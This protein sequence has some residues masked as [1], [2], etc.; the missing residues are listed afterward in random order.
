MRRANQYLVEYSFI[1][2]IV[3]FLVLFIAYPVFLNFRISF[4]DLRAANLLRGDAAWVGFANYQK[5][6]NDPLVRKAAEHLIMFTAGSLTFQ[7]PIGLGLALFFRQNFL[8]SKWMRGMFLLAWTMPII[9]VGAIFRWLFD[10]QFGVINWLVVNLGLAQENVQWLT[11]LD[12]VLVTLVIIN[13][14]LG[15]PFNMA[16]ILA[17]L[18]GLPAD[19]YEAA[20]VDGAT[21]QQQFRYITLPLLRPTLLAVFLLGLIFTLRTFDLIWSTTQ[22]G[23]FDASQVLSTIAYRRVFQQFL[24]GEG[25]AILNILF[26][27]LL[28]IAVIYVWSIRTEETE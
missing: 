21:K 26:F 18:Q 11:N 14:W 16:L 9:V 8:G 15:V 2:P 4:Q 3:A 1:A 6:V 27:V 7:I 10:S 20:T 19:V 12:S 5:I 23:P 13:I 24:F 28:G 17:G 25:A 22:G